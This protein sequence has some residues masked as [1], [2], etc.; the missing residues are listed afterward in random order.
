MPF[1]SS[2]SSR[3][4]VR[5]FTLMEVLVALAIFA[6]AAIVLGAS[7]VNVLNG[8]AIVGKANQT[9]ED[10]AFARAQMIAE[11]DRKLVEE[12]GEFE[13]TGGR[14][15]KWT[16]TIVSTTINDL[17]TVTFVCEISADPGKSESDRITET[18]TLLRP[19][20]SE[21]AER[22]QLLENVKARIQE[23]QGKKA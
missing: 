19:T 16:A 1:T 20:W 6:L 11:P 12:G 21:P 9:N 8:Y 4:R 7:Y 10:L 15:V 2:H 18:F 3:S 22:G 13:S 14:R 23:L 17:F 5:A